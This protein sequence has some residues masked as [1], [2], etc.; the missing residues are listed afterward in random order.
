MRKRKRNSELKYINLGVL[1]ATKDS[2]ALSK[3]IYVTADD[4]KSLKKLLN[5]G[6][7]IDIQQV[8]T[9]SIVTV[10]EKLLKE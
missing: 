8:P 10:N 6:I 4:I 7:K 9:E 3:A 5:Q 1:P 2:K